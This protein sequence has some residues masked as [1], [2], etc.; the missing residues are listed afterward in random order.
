MRLTVRTNL[1]MRTLMYCGV[2]R[3]HYVRK[4]A[5]AKA[6]HASENHLAQVINMLAHGGF[7]TTARGRNG[8]IALSRAP[9]EISLGEVFRT[10]E[11]GVPF[12]E[13]FA[14]EDNTCPLTPFCR[15][16]GAI[17]DA[18]DAFYARLDS[19]TLHELIEGN[20]DLQDFMGGY[21][22]ANVV[23]A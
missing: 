5:V 18:L 4:S 13:C 17:C 22:D 10:F 14:G 2:Y 15:L 19:I 3:G 21:Y 12:T 1:A 11:A 9:K 16:R 7:I 8:G 23:N 20:E 6:C